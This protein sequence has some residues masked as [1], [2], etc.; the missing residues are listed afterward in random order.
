MKKIYATRLLALLTGLLLLAC[1]AAMAEAPACPVNAPP[2]FGQVP[3]QWLLFTGEPV[4]YQITLHIDEETG[5]RTYTIENPLDWGLD[6]SALG[7]WEYAAPVA[8]ESAPETDETAPE[9]DETADQAPSAGSW[10]RTGDSQ[11]VQLLLIDAAYQEEGFP[12]W[13]APCAN[14]ADQLRLMVY[15]GQVR[16]LY[17]SVDYYFGT[18]C[19][20]IYAEDRSFTVYMSQTAQDGTEPSIYASYDPYGILAYANY[21][22]YAADNSFLSYAVEANPFQKC[23]QLTNITVIDPEGSAL[24]WEAGQ[25][26]NDQYEP[27]EAPEGIQPEALPFTIEG[28]WM[29]APFASAGDQPSGTFPAAALPQTEGALLDHQPWPEDGS[30]YLTLNALPQLP[31]VSWD[32]A[33]NGDLIFTV[34]GLENSGL[35]ETHMGDWTFHPETFEWQRGTESTPGQLT[36]LCPPVEAAALLI[37][38]Q[39]TTQADVLFELCL[40]LHAQ[41]VEVAIIGPGERFWR[42]STD[43]AA[44][45][46]Y[47]LSDTQTL[48][49]YYDD[50]TLVEYNL[51][52]ADAQGNR[53]TQACYNP[54]DAD[55]T[56]FEL[57]CFFRYS[58]VTEY[59]A[60]WI[61]DV[62]WYS[63]LTG[64]PCEA[65]EGIDLAAYAPLEL[66]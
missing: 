33:E 2:A 28:D 51:H 7:V 3:V 48:E 26:M 25:W 22:C 10:Q 5:L 53:L 66:R 41:S 38:Q 14:G 60:L 20:S 4:D 65:P 34:T 43:G 6:A 21:S 37:W 40:S 50:Y 47:P 9:T 35:A 15:L 16:H 39:E 45:L 46:C 1:T 55:P 57:S 52:T 24:Y 54:T 59:E 62:G 44:S 12:Q 32:T 61:K 31:A 63:Y 17:A 27:I 56:Q 30:L 23:Y 19:I 29:G 18:D 42:L 36:L 8:A 49:A 11:Q 13:C 64:E 58:P